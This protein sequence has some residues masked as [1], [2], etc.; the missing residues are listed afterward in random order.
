MRQSFEDLLGQLKAT[1]PNLHWFL[2]S[3]NS[4][5]YRDQLLQ[6]VAIAPHQNLGSRL[7]D[8]V[9]NTSKICTSERNIVE[10][11]F[12]RVCNMELHGNQY[13]IAQQLTRASG[14]QPTPDQPEISI[15]LDVMCVLWRLCTPYSLQYGLVPGVSYADHGRDLLMRLTKENSLCGTKGLVFNRPNMFALVTNREILNGSVTMAN[16]MDPRQTELPGLTPE[17]LMGITLGPLSIDSSHGYWTGYQ[18]DDTLAVQQ[19][20]YQTPGIYHQQ[21]SQV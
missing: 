7:V 16:L 6:P 9:A 12:A 18:E 11:S 3:N 21:A 17:E 5:P 4:Q 19:A 10:R 14:V 13:P 15:W 2:P 8:V 20:N 1:N